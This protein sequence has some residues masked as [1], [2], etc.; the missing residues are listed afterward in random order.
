MVKVNLIDG[1]Q[2]KPRKLTPEEYNTIPVHV[3][4]VMCEAWRE[5]NTIRARDG[6]P[7]GSNMAQEYW[8]DIMD[9]LN[10]IIESATGY[11]AHCHPSLYK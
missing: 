7:K 11:T 1:G 8:D 9:R 2:Q 5:M 10:K 4:K 6:V 3:I